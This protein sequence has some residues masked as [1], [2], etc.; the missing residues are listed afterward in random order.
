MTFDWKEQIE[1]LE[2]RRAFARALG[3]PERIDRRHARGMLTIRERIEAL[4][5]SFQEVGMLARMSDFDADGSVVNQHPA[6]YVCG[7]GE[8]DGRP[9]AVGGEDF[10]VGAGAPQTYLDRM[11]GG[12]GG[13]VD[14]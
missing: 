3:G 10:T 6:S 11:K 14:D 7:L 8:V 13:F 9:V 1:E 5:S 2:R 4:T 12:L